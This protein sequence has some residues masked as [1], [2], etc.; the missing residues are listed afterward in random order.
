[1]EPKISA[2]DL[3]CGAGGLTSGLVKSGIPVEAGVDADPNCEFAFRRNHRTSKF[4]LR[5]ICEIE[6]PDLEE[7]WAPGSV[8]LLA[9]CAPC[10]PFST[11]NQARRPHQ[12]ERWRLLDQ[13]NRLIVET[14]PEF[15]TM[16]NVP[17]LEKNGVYNDFHKSLSNLGYNVKSS[18]L[19]CAE[20]GV[21]QNRHRLV[22]IAA[23]EPFVLGD[24]NEY[25]SKPITVRAAIRK[26]RALEAGEFDITDPLHR[27][28][29]LS[30]LNME[31]IK[32]SN[33]GGTWHDWPKSLRAKCHTK[34]KGNGYV[35]VY[36][37]MSWDMPSPTITTQCY[38]YGSGRFGHP[39]QNRAI[40]L[41]EAAILQG[42]A[43]RYVFQNSRNHI[44][45]RDVA[46]LIGNA[47]PPPLGKA[48]GLTILSSLR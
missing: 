7:L 24:I 32:T 9:G 10:Q 21:P 29:S 44:S 12:D 25:K 8:R 27:S 43:K 16:E 47:V 33:P 30:E 1:M 2:I 15:V 35:G 18:V 45:T 6:A 36:G 19:N 20:F 11:F 5:D 46:K 22:L 37:R 38:N 41:R 23:K 31:R 3:F 40:S 34:E 28:A 48:I 17:S 42:F 14:L 4:V 13:F 39:D 26:L